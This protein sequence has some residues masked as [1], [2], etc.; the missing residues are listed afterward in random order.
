[1]LSLC[2]SNKKLNSKFGQLS[3]ESRCMSYVWFTSSAGVRTLPEISSTS[4]SSSRSTKSIYRHNSAISQPICKILGSLERGHWDLSNELKK[5]KIG[6]NCAAQWRKRAKNAF[7]AIAPRNLRQ[8]SISWA[9]L[10]DLNVLFP[11]S[12]R[13]CKS[14]EKW[15]SYGGI[16]PER[17]SI[18]RRS[19]D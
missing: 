13:F 19:I 8:F 1:M 3:R 17:S 2:S 18:D 12:P 10:I 6:A 4:R 16:S 15:L 7:C 5:I 9:H 14:V 11:T